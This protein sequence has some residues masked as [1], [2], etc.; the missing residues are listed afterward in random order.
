MAWGTLTIGGVVLRETFSADQDGPM[1]R[2]WRQQ[3]LRRCLQV[4]AHLLRCLR[5]LQSP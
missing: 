1:L 4:Q 3:N 5:W 2:P